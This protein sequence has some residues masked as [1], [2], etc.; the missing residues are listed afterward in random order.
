MRCSSGSP[1]ACRDAQVYIDCIVHLE[2]SPLLGCRRRSSG[3]VLGAELASAVAVTLDVR[4]ALLDLV[5][6]RLRAV[7]SSASHDSDSMRVAESEH[8]ADPR[9]EVTHTL[10]CLPSVR[11]VTE[12]WSRPATA[13][14]APSRAA[15][16]F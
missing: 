10:L 4:D 14:P 8:H 6:A 9:R 15:L 3:R 2:R 16:M 7:E 11:E 1:I 12:P 5:D 13:S